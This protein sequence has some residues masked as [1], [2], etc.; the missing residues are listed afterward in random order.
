MTLALRVVEIAGMLQPDR[1]D[2]VHEVAQAARG[3]IGHAHPAVAR[4]EL[5]EAGVDHLLQRRRPVI[6]RLVLHQAAVHFFY[7][8]KPFIAAAIGQLSA[9]KVVVI[10]R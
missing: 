8:E 10:F 2:D 1:L 7:A 6:G 5:G 4:V 9:D 3:E